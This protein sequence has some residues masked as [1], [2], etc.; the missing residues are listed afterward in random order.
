MKNFFLPILLFI[1]GIASAQIDSSKATLVVTGYAEVYYS[2]DFNQPVDH[3]RPSFFYSHN[4]YN[5][6]NLNLGFL[7]TSYNTDRVHANVA[8]AAGTYMNANYSAEQGVMKN[9]YEANAGVK[10]SKKKNLWMDAGIFAS[11]IGFESAVAKDCWGLTRSILADNSPY[12]ESGAK[13][14]YTSD[15]SKWFLSGLILN[16]WQHIQRPDYNNTPAFGTQITFTPDTKIT[17]NY[18]TFIGNEKADTAKQMR[19]F[20]NFYGMFHVTNKFHITAGIDYGMEQKSK[21]SSDY[22]N[23][24]SPVIVVKM[25]LNGQWSMSVRGEYYCDKNGV[26][27]VTGTENG[28]QTAGY[29][30]NFDYKIRENVMWRIEGRMLTSKDNIFVK[31]GDTINTNNFVTSSLAI[32]F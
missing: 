15:N 8:L 26:I 1:S 13:I 4:R 14:S 18:S 25:D 16:G 7:K 3:N 10:I 17:L 5:E 11:H 28:F 22:N 12:Y 29:S 32:S 30:V 27:I 6:F 24:Y 20:H 19:Y 23:W 31:A 9:I 2:Y 21:G